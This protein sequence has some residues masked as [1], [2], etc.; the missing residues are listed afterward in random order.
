MG[1]NNNSKYQYFYSTLFAIFLIL[2][3]LLL[4]FIGEDSAVGSLI[5]KIAFLLISLSIV[6]IPLVFIKP[7]YYGFFVII[8]FPIII[9]ET[10][11]VIHFKAPSSEEIINSVFQTNYNEA[12][13]ILQSNIIFVLFSLITFILFFWILNKI[14]KSFIVNRKIKKLILIFFACTFIGLGTRNLR[15]ALKKSAK[16]SEI[17]QSFNYSFK[18]QMQKNFPIGFF[19]KSLE[20]FEGI[21]KRRTYLSTIKNFSFNAIKKDTLSEKEI[22]IL[23]IGETARKHNFSIYN[24]NRKTSPNLDTIKNLMVFNNVKSNSN[25][26]SLSIPFMLTRA[27]PKKSKIKFTEPTL[28]NVFKE[29]GFHTYWVSNQQIATGSVF[30]LYSQTSDSYF[31]VSKSLDSAGFDENV[32]PVFDEILR[33]SFKKKFIIIHTIGS[34]FRYNYRYPNNFKNFLPTLEKGLSI[35]S[36][37]NYNKKEEIINSYDN[38]LLYTDFILSEL[39]KKTKKENVNSFLFYISDHGENLFDTEKNKLLHGYEIPTKFE[40]EIPL[41]I[42]TSNKYNLNHPKII[43]SLH[44]NTNNKIATTN[45][46]YTLSDMSNI[47]YPNFEKQHSFANKKFDTLQE[48]FFYSVNKS[49]L[50]LD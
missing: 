27:T 20:I 3:N 23:V 14:D 6:L 45:T 38:S 9:F 13:E 21:K 43:E 29:T 36:T 37:T 10:Y 47:T 31:N 32:L 41:L 1:K 19:I 17:I 35:E 5:K 16:R 30:G 49:V 34:H 26:T 46:F 44:K 11:H 28:I 8:F 48:R 22:Y 18:V 42:W 12:K 50:K 33:D 40:T 2:P 39:I 25:V 15:L 24:Y 4:I 7:K